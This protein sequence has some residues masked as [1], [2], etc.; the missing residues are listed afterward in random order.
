MIQYLVV[1]LKRE[2]NSLRHRQTNNRIVT[3]LTFDASQNIV[4]LIRTDTAGVPEDGG[5]TRSMLRYILGKFDMATFRYFELS[6]TIS[7]TTS[8]SVSRRS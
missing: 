7:N 2:S 8:L 4:T 1:D 6:I 3:F 5:K